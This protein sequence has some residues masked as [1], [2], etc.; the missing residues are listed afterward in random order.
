MIPGQSFQKHRCS[1]LQSQ[2]RI[3]KKNT[4]KCQYE[5]FFTILNSNFGWLYNRSNRQFH[6]SRN[7]EF[8]KP[9]RPDLKEEKK[10]R[11]KKAQ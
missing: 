1:P 3:I 2:R 11:E 9:A 7:I 8:H 10:K 4:F 5:S 6:G